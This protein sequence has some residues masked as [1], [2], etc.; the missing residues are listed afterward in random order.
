MLQFVTNGEVG[1]YG[2]DMDWECAHRTE[3][4]PIDL[5]I[6]GRSLQVPKNFTQA[7]EMGFK[8]LSENALKFDPNN[9]EWRHKVQK[10]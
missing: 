3:S 7:A 8:I 9:P 4:E 1:D 2:F 6:N 5:F 10:W